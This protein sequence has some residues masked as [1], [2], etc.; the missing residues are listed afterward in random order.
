MPLQWSI[1][2]LARFCQ[3]TDFSFQL[4]GH[5]SF[6][7]VKIVLFSPVF[8]RKVLHSAL[9]VITHAPEALGLV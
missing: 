6:V 1:E 9:L 3:Y 7:V 8:L 4:G 2:S 5:L